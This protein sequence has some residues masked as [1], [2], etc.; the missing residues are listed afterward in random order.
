MLEKVKNI[1]EIR[2]VKTKNDWKNF[3][4][5]PL[6]LYKDNP[7]YVPAIFSDEKNIANTKKN[8]SA[9]GCTVRA[10]LCYKDGKIAGRIAGIIVE[11][12]NKK[13][14]EKAI[15][16]SRFDF[17]D[18]KEVSSALIDA[19]I[20]FGIEYGMTRIHGPW[21]FNDTDREGLLT[22]GF[23]EEGSYATNYNY[24]YYEEHLTS[25][26]FKD[27]SAWIEERIEFPKKDDPVHV[28][29]NRIKD[30]VMKKFELKDVSEELSVKQIVKIYGE[31]FFD[32]YNEAYKHL[33]MYV[34]LDGKAKQVV[35]R[36]FAMMVNP[37]FFSLLVN[38]KDEVVAFVVVLPSIGKAFKKHDGKMTLPC[39]IDLLKILKNPKK[40]ELTLVAVRPEFS[41]LGFNSACITKVM[42]NVIKYNIPEVVS[43]PTLESNIDVRAQWK[44]LKSEVIK[45]RKTFTKNID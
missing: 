30:Y 10:F 7:Y 32:C 4:K 45:R 15:R 26:G 2:Q 18:D 22:F 14:N 29:Y 39:I 20:N 8:F 28:R 17:I 41:K 34:K 40:L 31:K 12:S 27:E 16:F 25:L 13:W 9:I 11:E 33:D 5:F 42:N 35:L 36:Q 23:E 1:I 6:I 38:K 24:P 43:D 44:H 3:A 21:G 19:V 37:K